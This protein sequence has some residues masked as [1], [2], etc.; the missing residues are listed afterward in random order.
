MGGMSDRPSS[1]LGVDRFATTRWSLVL[2]ARNSAT[3]NARDA[4]ATLC[5]AYWYPLYTFVRRRGHDAD[6]AQ[7]LT[8]AFFVRLL[9]KDYLQVVDQAKGRFR[10]FLLAS[11]THFLHNEYD[12]ARA[13]KRGGGRDPWSLDFRDAEGKYR[14]E[15]ADLQTPERLFER[16]WALTLL[17]QVLA[18]LQDEWTQ[19]GRGELFER[20]KAYLLEDPNAVPYAETAKDLKTSEAAIKMAVHRMRKR[21]RALLHEEIGRTVDDPSEIGNEI[22]ALF[23]ALGS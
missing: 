3:P 16:R 1:A 5:Q 18:R 9:E 14:L 19:S 22:Q 10:S 21:Y 13:Q 4:L 17:E 12:R 20:L 23:A 2:A 15:P 7:D 6:E 11:L 8:Q